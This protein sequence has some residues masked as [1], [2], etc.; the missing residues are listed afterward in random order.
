M[1]KRGRGWRREETGSRGKLRW[2]GAEEGGPDRG[3][4]RAI[5]IG[6]KEH[7]RAHDHLQ[8]RDL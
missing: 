5:D 7:N 1:T 3:S 4:D 8:T 6:K 2:Q